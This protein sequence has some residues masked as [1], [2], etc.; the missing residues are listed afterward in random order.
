[1]QLKHYLELVEDFTLDEMEAENAFSIPEQILE[2]I[3]KKAL[4]EDNLQK[5]K[6][7]KTES[8]KVGPI[9]IDSQEERENI[10]SMKVNL[11]K[12]KNIKE[13]MNSFQKERA[14]L[15]QSQRTIKIFDI[16]IVIVAHLGVL[17]AFIDVCSHL[18][19]FSFSFI[20]VIICL[21]L[22]NEITLMSFILKLTLMSLRV[23]LSIIFSDQSLLSSLLLLVT[24]NSLIKSGL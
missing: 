22:R 14:L 17:T 12:N 19:I 7:E 10:E 3:R 11:F 9:T 23:F 2:N 8:F 21:Q 15:L 16:I 1:M 13:K 20:R 18:L 6:K 4:K 5:Q 24:I